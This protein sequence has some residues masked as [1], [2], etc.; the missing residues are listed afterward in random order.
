[1]ANLVMHLITCVVIVGA[2]SD[3]KRFVGYV[4][5]IPQVLSFCLLPGVEL[6]VG[7]ALGGGPESPWQVLCGSLEVLVGSL[8]D[9]QTDLSC[10]LRN[11]NVFEGSL[12][13]RKFTKGWQVIRSGPGS[14][15]SYG[16]LGPPKLLAEAKSDEI[17]QT[18]AESSGPN[19]PWA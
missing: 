13:A 11:S 3:V 9:P 17:E 4:S 10:V 14:G 2:Q 8:G 7:Q 19:P 5:L 16:G 18:K 6:G 1:M 15:L 12:G